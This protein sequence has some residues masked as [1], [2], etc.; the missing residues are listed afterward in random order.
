MF[1]IGYEKDATKRKTTIE[2]K[3]VHETL[4]LGFVPKFYGYER[5]IKTIWLGSVDK[6]IRLG[7]G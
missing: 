3:Y 6:R 7:Y 2:V 5:L 1:Q 4:R